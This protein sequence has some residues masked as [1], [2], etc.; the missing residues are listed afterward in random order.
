[1]QDALSGFKS[2]GQMPQLALAFDRALSISAMRS[3]NEPAAHAL[4]AAPHAPTLPNAMTAIAPSHD[5]FAQSQCRE[6]G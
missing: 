6:E 3:S 1:L 4:A 5:E 2:G